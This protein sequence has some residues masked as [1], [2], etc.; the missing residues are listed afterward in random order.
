MEELKEL[1]QA[2]LDY[3]ITL[4]T[5]GGILAVTEVAK[6]KEF[7]TNFDQELDDASRETLKTVAARADLPEDLRQVL[8]LRLDASRAPKKSAAI[9]RAH[10][11]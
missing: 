4:L 8:Q 1:A 6:I 3:Q 5:K 7:A 9:V 2:Q 11:G 10:V